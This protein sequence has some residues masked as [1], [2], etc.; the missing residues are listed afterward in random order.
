MRWDVRREALT[1]NTQIDV[2]CARR[3]I[4]QCKCNS[5]L[6]WQPRPQIVGPCIRRILLDER[7]AARDVCTTWSAVR[8]MMRDTTIKGGMGE[9]IGLHETKTGKKNYTQGQGRLPNRN[10]EENAP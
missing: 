10:L 1:T 8:P 5:Q 9:R 3:I 6:F 7:P 2:M 4:F